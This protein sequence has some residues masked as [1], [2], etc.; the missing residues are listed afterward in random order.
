LRIRDLID[1][2]TINNLS[3]LTLNELQ[4]RMDSFG[5]LKI[6]INKNYIQATKFEIET[7]SIK[8]AYY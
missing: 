3:N 8:K 2:I 1:I 7:N 4:Y 6:I 5:L